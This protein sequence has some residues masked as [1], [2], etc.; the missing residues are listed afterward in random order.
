MAPAVGFGVF[1]LGA[2]VTRHQPR[3][4]LGAGRAAPRV[5]RS[6]CRH[7]WRATSSNPRSLAPTGVAPAGAPD[8]VLIVPRHRARGEH[9]DVRLRARH[10][11]D[12]LAPSPPRGRCFSTYGAVD[13]VAAVARVAVH[14]LFRRGTVRTRRAGRSP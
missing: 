9:V 10:D 12:V 11:A 13:V 2:L 7:S 6:R 5:E 8:V 3:A 14:W 1:V 4:G